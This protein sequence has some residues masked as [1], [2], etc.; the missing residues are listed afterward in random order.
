M[1]VLR[2]CDRGGWGVE[3]GEVSSAWQA[4]LPLGL[5][6]IQVDKWVSHFKGQF[7]WLVVA[8]GGFVEKDWNLHGKGCWDLLVMS[9]VGTE[10]E[11]RVQVPTPLQEVISIF[12]SLSGKWDERK[13]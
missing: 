11:I 10:G 7:E 1:C 5:P 8:P 12:P 3:E 9:A 4:T 13:A 2:V 6:S